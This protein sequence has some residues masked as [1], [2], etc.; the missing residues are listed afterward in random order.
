M[1]DGRVGAPDANVERRAGFVD[2]GVGDRADLQR[3]TRGEREMVEGPQPAEG[4]EELRS[5]Q[6]RYRDNSKGRS[7]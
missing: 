7:F 2:I 4:H 6:C 1:L 5:R 3:L